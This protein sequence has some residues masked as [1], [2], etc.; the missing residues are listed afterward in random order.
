MSFV[1][2]ILVVLF[3]QYLFMFD[4]QQKINQVMPSVYN[5]FVN[6]FE[7]LLGKTGDL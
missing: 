7:G 2:G 6:Q 3:A 1:F 4:G 5:K